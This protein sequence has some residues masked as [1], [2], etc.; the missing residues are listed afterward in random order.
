MLNNHSF[1]LSCYLLH[2]I[3]CSINCLTFIRLLLIFLICII[4]LYAY[5]SKSTDW[6]YFIASIS[7]LL[8]NLYVYWMDLYINCCLDWKCCFLAFLL[9]IIIAIVFKWLNSSYTRSMSESLILL[10]ITVLLVASLL[11]FCLLY[12][13]LLGCFSLLSWLLISCCYL[14]YWI[15]YLTRILCSSLYFGLLHNS[16]K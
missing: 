9:S 2:W 16:I 13:W 12:V 15:N 6:L 4:I 11:L 1:K 3:N 5:L 14:R 7:C 10:L 8:L